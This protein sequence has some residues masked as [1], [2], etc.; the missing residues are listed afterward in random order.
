M[1]VDITF[2]HWLII[3][4]VMLVLELFAPG[5]FMLW[6]AIA[7][8]TSALL[9][10]VLPDLSWQ[11]Q[12]LW[13]SVFCIASL[14]L[15]RKVARSRKETPSDQPNLNRRTQRYVGRVFNLSEAIEN[16]FGKI[17]VDDSQWRVAGDD[18][19]QGAKVKVVSA[20]GVVLQVEVLG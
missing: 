17:V 15:W 2:W 16:G 5:A 8:L 7:A 20:E 13:F 6:I 14:L 9:A 19:P 11:W 10:F 12:C 18:A 3:A 4:G 1:M